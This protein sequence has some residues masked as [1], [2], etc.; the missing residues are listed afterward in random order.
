MKHWNEKGTFFVQA[1]CSYTWNAEPFTP[2][3]EARL[4][5][6]YSQIWIRWFS[7]HSF[8][9]NKLVLIQPL[10]SI[11]I[12]VQ[13]QLWLS[14][15]NSSSITYWIQ[16]NNQ[17]G[18]WLQ[19]SS[20]K[21]SIRDHRFK[22]GQNGS[23]EAVKEYYNQLCWVF[24]ENRQ[25]QNEYKYEKIPFL[26]CLVSLHFYKWSYICPIMQAEATTQ[27]SAR[28]NPPKIQLDCYYTNILIM[29]LRRQQISQALGAFVE[30]DNKG[31]RN[32]DQR[33]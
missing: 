31:T 17:S 11:E 30:S 15:W 4:R 21:V 13:Y 14:I 12:E 24:L 3:E 2:Y 1:P 28:N 9:H 18:S 22:C 33:S 25:L 16:N 23:R 26:T 32:E 5:K 29:Q 7:K 19:P 20:T 6:L 27:F 8:Q 10:S